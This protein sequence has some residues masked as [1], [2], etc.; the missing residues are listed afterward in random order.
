LGTQPFTEDD[1]ALHLANSTRYGLN[2]TIFTRDIDRAFR[3]ADR[4]D[5]GDVDVNCH[6]IPNVNAGRGMPRRR[7]GMSAVGVASYERPKGV[8][9]SMAGARQLTPANWS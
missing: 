2:A 4:L 1:Q 3:L 9:I 5:V 8:N 7:S 6:F